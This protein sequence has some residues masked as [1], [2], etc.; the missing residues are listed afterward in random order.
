MFLFVADQ[1]FKGQSKDELSFVAGARIKVTE[2]DFEGDR[3]EGWLYGELVSESGDN[4]TEGYFPRSHGHVGSDC[5]SPYS[6]LSSA[7]LL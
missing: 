1:A 5:E 7:I 2:D 3:A 4:I 6:H